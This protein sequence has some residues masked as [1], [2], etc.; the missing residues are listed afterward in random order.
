MKLTI[1]DKNTKKPLIQCDISKDASCDKVATIAI[2]MLTTLY[3]MGKKGKG[4]L[5]II[6]KTIGAKIQLA[7]GW[8]D[9]YK[10]HKTLF[11]IEARY[12]EDELCR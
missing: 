9:S 1:E 7:L 4:Q 12:M 6:P 8:E 3:A 10:D 11:K 2:G 5:W